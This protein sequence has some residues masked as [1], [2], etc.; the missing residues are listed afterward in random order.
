MP[1]RKSLPHYLKNDWVFLPFPYTK[2][3][4]SELSFHN[5]KS[6]VVNLFSNTILAASQY[7]LYEGV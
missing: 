3:F 4:T 2:I 5:K 1:N 6:A 7:V